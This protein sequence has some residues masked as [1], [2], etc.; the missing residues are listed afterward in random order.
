MPKNGLLCR[1]NAITPIQ[2]YLQKKDN[3]NLLVFVIIGSRSVKQ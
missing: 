2:L 3:K 1:M